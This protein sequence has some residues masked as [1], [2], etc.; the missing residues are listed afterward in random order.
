[1]NICPCAQLA[2]ESAQRE[3][4]TMSRSSGATAPAATVMSRVF[5]MQ[6]WAVQQMPA[7]D[8]PCHEDDLDVQ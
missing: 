7:A 1:M 5:A 2:L 6:A 3:I 8:L 4:A